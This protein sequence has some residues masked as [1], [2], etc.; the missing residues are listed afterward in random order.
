METKFKIDDLVYWVSSSFQDI[1]PKSDVSEGVIKAIK[2]VLRKDSLTG[3]IVSDISYEIDNCGRHHNV[4]VFEEY[5]HSTRDEVEEKLK[6][7]KNNII[8]L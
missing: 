6:L 4:E 3:S 5:L 8:K 1:K 2:I 7:R